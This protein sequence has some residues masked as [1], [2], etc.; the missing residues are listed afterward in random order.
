MSVP[1]WHGQG[2]WQWYPSFGP[3]FLVVSAAEALNKRH[4]FEISCWRR[5]PPDHV[6][7]R[8]LPHVRQHTLEMQVTYFI[9]WRAYRA[10]LLRLLLRPGLGE[11]PGVKHGKWT[12]QIKEQ[13]ANRGEMVAFHLHWNQNSGMQMSQAGQYRKEPFVMRGL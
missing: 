2:T 1:T 3:I 8:S 9:A 11:E 13:D 10:T 7:S 4:N 6:L 12:N 5:D